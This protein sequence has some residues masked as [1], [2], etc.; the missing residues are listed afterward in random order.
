[1]TGGFHRCC[2]AVAAQTASRT[3]APALSA[4]STRP[5]R[6]R[7]SS[8]YRSTRAGA[9]WSAGQTQVPP[10][11]NLDPA[12]SI[13]AKGSRSQL[14][15]QSGLAIELPQLTQPCPPCVKVNPSVTHRAA[16]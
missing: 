5:E 15:Q 6:E 12:A 2:Q 9:D 14:L 13:E 8:S 1:M 10:S 3:P 11:F 16:R 4:A 7:A